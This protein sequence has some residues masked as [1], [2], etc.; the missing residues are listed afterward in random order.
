MKLNVWFFNVMG[1]LDSEIPAVFFSPM[2]NVASTAKVISD[3]TYCLFTSGIQIT[4]DISLNC[5]RITVGR[6][7][8]CGTGKVIRSFD[9]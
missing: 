4:E 7:D 1:I 3:G 6:I 2:F 9:C 5:T 8:V